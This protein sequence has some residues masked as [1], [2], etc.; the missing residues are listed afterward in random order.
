MANPAKS[1]QGQVTCNENHIM[2]WKSFKEMAPD[3]KFMSNLFCIDCLFQTFRDGF[4]HCDECNK[5]ICQ[6]CGRDNHGK[7]YLCI[8][9]AT[10]IIITCAYI[11][12]IH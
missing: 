10:E 9:H 12:P 5:Q 11:L 2:V 4:Y 6:T 7:Y 3:D 1:N 8:L